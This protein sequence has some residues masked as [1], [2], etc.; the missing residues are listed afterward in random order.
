MAYYIAFYFF[1]ALALVLEQTII[2][3]LGHHKLILAWNK[4]CSMDLLNEEKNQG[5]S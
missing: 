5:T 1:I 4:L 2:I 3:T